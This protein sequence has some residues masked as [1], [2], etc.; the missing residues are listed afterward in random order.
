MR[1]PID[2]TSMAFISAGIPTPDLEFGT[3]TQK[4]DKDGVALYTV[5]VMAIGDGFPEVIKVKTA[6]QPTGISI[7]TTVRLV[8][9]YAQPYSMGDRSG[10]SFR[11]A[12]IE[13]VTAAPAA[14][15]RSGEAR[16]KS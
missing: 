11:A 6:G 4:T 8:G 13:A 9:L 16:D 5:A 1:L 3:E 12:S 2:T 15:V 14:P 10:V 7:G